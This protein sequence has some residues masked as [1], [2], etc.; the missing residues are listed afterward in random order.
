MVTLEGSSLSWA[1]GNWAFL[2]VGLGLVYW[3]GDLFLF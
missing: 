2:Q 3:K 1:G